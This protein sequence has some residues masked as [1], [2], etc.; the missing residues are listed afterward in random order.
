MLCT[1]C[2]ILLVIQAVGSVGRGLY[3]EV[4]AR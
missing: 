3:V 4:S 1:S 2:F